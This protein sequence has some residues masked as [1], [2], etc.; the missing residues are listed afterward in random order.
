MTPVPSAPRLVCVGRLSAQ[1]GQVI[2][3]EA[4]A[5]LAAEGVPFEIVFVGGGEMQADL[6]KSVADHGLGARV[7]MTGWADGAAVRKAYADDGTYRA[8][9]RAALR[10]RL[11]Q[12]PGAP[13]P[14]L[15]MT[16]RR[17]PE[18]ATWHSGQH[19]RQWIMLLGLQGITA[20]RP[21]TQADF[22]GLPMPLNA[23]DG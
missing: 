5:K 4:A 11:A 1:K 12:V 9:L 15:P 23:W 14:V 2:L 22:A 3:I 17:D 20:D 6:E 13:E 8:M 19:V 10:A 21:L 7:R 18:R 16:S